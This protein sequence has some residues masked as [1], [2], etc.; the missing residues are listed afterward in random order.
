MDHYTVVQWTR[1]SHLSSPGQKSV[2]SLWALNLS[3]KQERGGGAL[4]SDILP[5]VSSLPKLGWK[6]R[7]C[8]ARRGIT[9]LGAPHQGRDIGETAGPSGSPCP[10]APSPFSSNT[11]GMSVSREALLASSE[12]TGSRINKQTVREVGLPKQTQRGCLPPPGLSS[13]QEHRRAHI[14]AGRH[15][16]CAASRP[17]TTGCRQGLMV[18]KV[19]SLG[20][21]IGPAVS[22]HALPP[23][24]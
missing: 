2:H 23:D 16:A 18:Q 4:P 14:R 9:M 8:R 15:T 11:E 21:L 1:V 6:S 10:Q 22:S 20:S 5:P 13:G 19:S 3:S 17:A 24:P 7:P 12:E